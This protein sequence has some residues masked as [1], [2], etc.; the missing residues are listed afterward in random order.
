[1]FAKPRPT[2]YSKREANNVGQPLTF[3]YRTN[4]LSQPLYIRP[5]G[6]HRY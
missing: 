5:I 2:V 4:V 1:M 6:T 3:T